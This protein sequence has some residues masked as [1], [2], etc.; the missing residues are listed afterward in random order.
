M[1]LNT[2]S[3]GLRPLSSLAKEHYNI[4]GL[5]IDPAANRARFFTTG[6]T[7][8]LELIDASDGAVRNVDTPDDALI[9]S[10]SWSPDGERLAFFA[11]YDDATHLYVTDL[12][13]GSSS[14]VTDTPVLATVS[15]SFEWSGDGQHLFVVLIPEN[16]G[17]EPQRDAV[18]QHLQVRKTADAENRLRTYPSLLEG[19]YE[20]E[21]L[22][23]YI[24][25]QLARISVADGSTDAIGEPAMIRNID[26][27]PGGDFLRVQTIQ[28]PFSYIVPVSQYAWTEEIW[29]LDGN[30]LATVRKSDAREGDPEADELEDF[31]RSFVSWRPDGEGIS[32]VAKPDEDDEENDDN[33]D[34]E[35]ANGADDEEAED[36]SDKH[37]VVQWL[38]PFD[39]DSM[40]VIFVADREIRGLTY[41]DAADLLFLEERHQGDD[42][43]YAVFMDEPDST[44]TIYRKDR[45]DFYDI[46]GSLATTTGSLGMNVARLTSDGASVYLSGTQYFE[47]FENEAPRPFLDRV[48]IRSG[49][50]ERVFESSEDVYEQITAILDD[51]AEYLMVQRQSPTMLPDSYR[52]SVADGAFTQLTENEDPNEAVTQAQ[53]DRFKVT[54]ADGFEFWMEVVMPRDWDGEPLPGLLWHYPRELDDQDAYDDSVRRYNKNAYPRIGSRTADILVEHGYAVL[55]PDWPIVGDRGTSNDNFVWSIVQNSTAVLDAADQ[56]GYIDRYRMAIGGHSYGAFGTANAMIHTSLFKAGIAGAGNYNRTLTPLGF[57]RERADLWRGADRYIQMSPIFWAER[58]DGALLMYHGAEDQNV[59][60]WPMNSE[61]MFHALNGLGKTAAMY[62]YPY[63]GHGPSAEETLLDMWTRWADWL[64]EHVKNA[65]DEPE[66]ATAE[67]P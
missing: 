39:D 49:E 55:K 18:P 11:H 25:G 35:G 51:D 7:N 5:Q 31:N 30:A 9:S 21:L 40:E 43:L 8:G 2:R 36:Y 48:E 23:H 15:T 57:Q 4:A 38:P 13:T 66:E 14:R 20:A 42:H 17:A 12:E 47:D 3:I 22:E 44:Y 28:K 33:N 16:R 37:R 1:F 32:F 60:T 45:D 46:P 62:M 24:T 52:Y 59:G 29:D 61:R 27:A 65:D 63:E 41:S 6:L 10:A 56:R 54:R 50:T 19:P 67:A 53:R 64:D 26:A 34:T 58:M